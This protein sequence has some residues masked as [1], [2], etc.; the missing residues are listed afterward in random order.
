MQVVLKAKPMTTTAS[1]GSTPSVSAPLLHACPCLVEGGNHLG[2]K[3]NKCD[4]VT[5]SPSPC[6]PI[7]LPTN[8]KKPHRCCPPYPAAT[9]RQ[10][11]CRCMAEVQ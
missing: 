4:G 8:N 2:N 11:F 6:T 1:T 5:H 7:I 9:S 3:C 10:T